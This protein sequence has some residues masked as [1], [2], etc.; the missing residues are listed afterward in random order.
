MREKRQVA[1]I[2]ELSTAEYIHYQ[3]LALVND[4]CIFPPS[5]HSKTADMTRLKA[6]YNI[7]PAKSE[8]EAHHFLQ[9]ETAIAM[10]G[11]DKSRAQKLIRGIHGPQPE[12]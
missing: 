6:E 11:S 3:I 12:L 4:T 5:S 9:L 10:L 2:G 8:E 1:L 7:F